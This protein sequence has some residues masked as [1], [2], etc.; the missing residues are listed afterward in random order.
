LLRFLLILFMTSL[1]F[2]SVLIVSFQLLLVQCINIGALIGGI[3]IPVMAQT[4]VTMAYFVPVVMLAV[5]VA[6]FASGTPR[7]VQSRPA[8][9]WKEMLSLCPAKAKK[10]APYPSSSGDRIPLSVILRVSLLIVPFCIAY[11]QMATTF[12]V[13][14][15]VMNKAFG[16]I[17]A[18]SM[19]NADAVAVLLFGSLV[20]NVIYPWCAAHNIK[21]PTTHKFA[22]GSAFGAAAIAWALFIESMIHREYA[23]TGGKISIM[24]QAMAY[25]LIGAGEIFAVSA[26]YEVAFT[27]SPPEKK[28]LSSA[29]NLFCI[30]SVPNVI[31][32]GLYQACMPWFMNAH[33][34]TQISHIKDY[35]TAHVGKYFW[36]LFVISVAGVLLNLIP[37]VREF[38]ESI[39]ERAS[40]MIRTPKTPIRP[41]RRE[42]LPDEETQ[43]LMIKRH[44]YYLKYGSGPQL[45]KLGSMRAG[46]GILRRSERI[47]EKHINR[48]VLSKLYR[49][50]PVLPGMGQ[51][52]MSRSADGRTVLGGGAMMRPDLP[53]RNEAVLS[54]ERSG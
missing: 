17:D 14:G 15:T 18:A 20:G 50:D 9:H 11:S 3:V 51:L 1:S 37:V 16:W 52:M 45:Y 40:D 12:I 8:V 39:E 25:I 53:P 13:Q 27:A 22:I 43:L 6:L 36:L 21:I 38:V 31:C 42:P 7:Y 10:A 34:R 2:V 5:G 41:P 48:R 32:I 35:T 24:W 44:Q 19:N 33:G 49:S 4:N 47:A 26:A 30:G 29:V 54:S 46:P 23:K 28:V